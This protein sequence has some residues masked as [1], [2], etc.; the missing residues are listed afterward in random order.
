MK[1]YNIFQYENN[2]KQTSQKN[3]FLRNFV[4]NADLEYVVMYNFKTELPVLTTKEIDSFVDRCIETCK[5][6]GIHY[7]AGNLTPVTSIDYGTVTIDVSTINEQKIVI[8]FLTRRAILEVGY[9]DARFTDNCSVGDYAYRLSKT[10]LYP[11]LDEIKL[12]WL[13]GV[14]GCSSSNGVAKH[15]YD[16]LSAG[17]F[18]YKYQTV[19][20]LK[21]QNSFD[22]LKDA[23]KE[24]KRANKDE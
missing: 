3:A 14:S 11:K 2:K 24:H 22:N 1:T 13:F 23:L 12:P 20:H 5:V 16:E 10:N 7:L 17:W 9:F 21:E 15:I 4:H 6:T 19:P 18:Q 8:E